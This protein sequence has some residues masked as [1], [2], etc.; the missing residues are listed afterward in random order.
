MKH[1]SLLCVEGE[2]NQIRREKDIT[3]YYINT[4][5][6][7]RISYPLWVLGIAK[8]HKNDLPDTSVSEMERKVLLLEILSS[9]LHSN[10]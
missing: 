7:Q 5:A 10:V 1:F 9:F 6:P 8:P 3:G 2:Q 4:A